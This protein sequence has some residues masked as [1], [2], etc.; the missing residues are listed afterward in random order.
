M[1]S[2]R[3]SWESHTGSQ[4]GSFYLLYMSVLILPS[5][6]YFHDGTPLHP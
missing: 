5:G 2:E 1:D 4:I 3:L 6:S